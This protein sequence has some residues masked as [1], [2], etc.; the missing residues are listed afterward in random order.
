[1]RQLKAGTAIA[2]QTCLLKVDYSSNVVVAFQPLSN[3]MDESHV[4]SI[5]TSVS[6]HI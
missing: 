1:M 3:F 2:A 6:Y 4:L 5:V